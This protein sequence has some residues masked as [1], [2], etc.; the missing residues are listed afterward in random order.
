MPGEQITLLIRGKNW[1]DFVI[2]H[3]C[4]PSEGASLST[5]RITKSTGVAT[6]AFFLVRDWEVG[7]ELC[8]LDTPLPASPMKG[9]VKRVGAW[10]S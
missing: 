10:T 8:S 6:G 5:G 3:V 1:I 4:H 7:T 2:A 9:E